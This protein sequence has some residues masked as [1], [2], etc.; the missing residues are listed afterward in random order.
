MS[1]IS[2]KS[3]AIALTSA[4]VIT[5]ALALKYPDRALFDE[6]REGIPHPKGS[7][8]LGNLLELLKNK[9]RIFMY[10]LENYESM[11]TFT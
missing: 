3:G 11:D 1:L 4:F 5:A 2:I 9:E 8:I 10:A 7:P 6:H